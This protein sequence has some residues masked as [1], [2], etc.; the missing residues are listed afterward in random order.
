[1]NDFTKNFFITTLEDQQNYFTGDFKNINSFIN[2]SNPQM[3]SGN[4]RIIDGELCQIINDK[5]GKML[6]VTLEK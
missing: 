5:N 6:A 4:Y 2:N 3:V 1:M